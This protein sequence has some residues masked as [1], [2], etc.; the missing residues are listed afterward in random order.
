L[1][2]LKTS[3]VVFLISAA[4]MTLSANAATIA[5]T[6]TADAGGTCPG[7]S[8]TLRQAIATAATGD[9]ISFSLPANSTISLT[10]DQLVIDK[11]M[12]INGPGAKLLTVTR[13]SAGAF[14]IFKINAGATVTL[15]GLTITNGGTSE[16]GGGIY[17]AGT[18]TVA[19]SVISGNSTGAYG[20]GIAN[21]ATL[22]VVDSTVLNNSGLGGGG[23]LN[24]L[25]SSLTINNSTVGP[26]NTAT[27]VVGGAGIYNAGTLTIAN[28]TVSGNAA[29]SSSGQGGGI[30]TEYATEL[31]NSTVAFNSAFTGGGVYVADSES[32]SI[33]STII[34]Q[35]TV[36]PG[37]SGPD[38][39]GIANL[40]GYN[41]IG[42]T[43]ATGFIVKYDN[44]TS[45][46]N[47]NPLLDSLKDNGGPTQTHALLSGSPAIDRGDS[48]LAFGG[49]NSD[50]RGYA[51]PV[52]SPLTSPP[53]D[54]A[55]VGAYEVQ[56]DQLPGCNTINRVVTNNNDSGADS[57]RDVIGKVCA[58]SVITFAPGVTGAINLTSGEL[59][60]NK[61]LT[62]SGPGA[63]V[64]TVQRAAGAP[65][66]R[67][68]NIGA[69]STTAISGLTIANGKVL[70][71][72]GGGILNAGT[73]SLTG[74]AVAGNTSGFTGGGILSTGKLNL[75]GSV[76]SGNSTGYSGGGLRSDGTL[77]IVD[78]TISG[79]SAG[80]GGGGG[81]MNTGTATIA[82]S[83]LS[84]NTAGGP[85]AG[86]VNTAT[87][88]LV[89]TTISGN[90]AT[91]QNGGGVETISV[92]TL[93]SCTIVGNSVT[94]TAGSGT[95]Y[96][97]GIGAS[98]T[99]NMTNTIVALNTAQTAGP[100]VY[101][102]VTSQG[103]NLVGDPANMTVTPVQF[104]DQVGVSAAQLNLGPLQD[105]GGPTQTRALL[106]GSVAIDKGNASGYATDQRGFARTIDL[107]GVGNATGGDGADIGAFE[108]GSGHLD[109]DGNK[110]YDALTDGVLL[111]RYLFGLTGAALTGG[112]IGAQPA[113]PTATEIVPF[114]TR[115]NPALDV[116]LDG[117]V[118][119]ST[120]GLMVLRYLLGYRGPGLTADAIGP[121]ATRT[122]AKIE[123][124]IQSLM[125]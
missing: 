122:P 108:F 13:G 73:L 23:I 55:D 32:V 10:S 62:I 29:S 121:G 75:I 52:L 103:F 34:A 105:N 79:N 54:G 116:D 16:G 94:G 56:A 97:G 80:P 87:M 114:L 11:S 117:A 20:G 26:G 57:L 50:Q 96:G 109:I 92:A 104:T 112:A 98:G 46:L 7:P 14:R 45:Q 38:V 101:G 102:H 65:D 36:A 115:M 66:A 86:I 91:N 88:T 58:G 72:T 21:A 3:L 60:I 17:N 95:G 2:S 85:G 5:V 64:L 44:G 78:S 18:L 42:N 37:G 30:W 25:N 59:A 1:D 40:Q 74:V 113:R 111:V 28:S 106:A 19:R 125:P 33:R 6:S 61:S 63:G 123:T 9:T 70:A 77:S 81:V 76:V 4:V 68:F 118:E 49:S 107:L 119:V 83:T 124:Y 15:S 48:S 120:D 67:I 110:H 47:V 27:G 93:I 43:S 24:L 39:Y 22:A 53:G 31:T 82:N 35:N 51:R 71:G 69:S 90:S 100:D 84:D 99:L 41:V 12:T 8:C 89:N